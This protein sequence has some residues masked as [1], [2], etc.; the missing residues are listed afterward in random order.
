MIR[1][2]ALL[3]VFAPALTL[4]LLG[5]AGAAGQESPAACASAVWL[6]PPAAATA[7]ADPVPAEIADA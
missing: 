5:I 4:P 6:E 1:R 2:L 7:A 3:T